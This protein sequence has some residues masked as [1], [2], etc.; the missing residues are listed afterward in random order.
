MH[1]SL[2]I[3]LQIL[4]SHYGIINSLKLGVEITELHV[5]VTPHL[6]KPRSDKVLDSLLHTR[7][8]RIKVPKG[9]TQNSCYYGGG[10]GGGI[11]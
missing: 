8:V 11:C 9:S 3:L 4:N 1:L 6:L 2:D 7:K 5:H 10:G